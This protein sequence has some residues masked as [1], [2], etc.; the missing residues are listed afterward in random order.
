MLYIA[1]LAVRPYHEAVVLAVYGYLEDFNLN[2]QNSTSSANERSQDFDFG[3]SFVVQYVDFV[4]QGAQA[5]CGYLC[6]R[7]YSTIGEA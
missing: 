1:L 5:H 7:S 4:L 2:I 3:Y 6:Q